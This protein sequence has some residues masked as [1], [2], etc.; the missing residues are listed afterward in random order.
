LGI[1][2]RK[3]FDNST[4]ETRVSVQRHTWV[5]DSDLLKVHGHDM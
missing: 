1:F 2:L 5:V 4:E 3:F